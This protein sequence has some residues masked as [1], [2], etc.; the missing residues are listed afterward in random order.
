MAY[1]FLPI[2]LGNIHAV[3][4][5]Y[6]ASLR[7]CTTERDYMWMVDVVHRYEQGDITHDQMQRELHDTTRRCDIEEL[8]RQFGGYQPFKVRIGPGEFPAAACLN[9]VVGTRETAAL[10]PFPMF[11]NKLFR[12]T[13]AKDQWIMIME[14]SNFCFGA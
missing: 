5:K 3:N 7:P 4:I 2:W 9:I 10:Y 11:D 1:R 6:F 12:W 8:T 13:K 14:F